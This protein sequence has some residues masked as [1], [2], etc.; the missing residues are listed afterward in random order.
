M[1]FFTLDVK[2]LPM[3]EYFLFCL[4]LMFLLKVFVVYYFVLYFLDCRLCSY[5]GP[6]VEVFFVNVLLTHFVKCH[7]FYQL[8]N[9]FFYEYFVH[10]I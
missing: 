5:Y 7:E 1:L 3:I 8:N 4:F 2:Y 6:Y 10:I 9:T